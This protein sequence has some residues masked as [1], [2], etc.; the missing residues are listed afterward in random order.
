MAF[1]VPSNDGFGD[2]DVGMIVFGGYTSLIRM[3]SKYRNDI[4][5]TKMLLPDQS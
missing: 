5:Q 1:C 2:K 4:Y 3:T